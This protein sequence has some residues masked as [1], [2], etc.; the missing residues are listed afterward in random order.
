MSNWS[1]FAF[2]EEEEEEEQQQSSNPLYDQAAS[3]QVKIQLTCGPPKRAQT[4]LTPLKIFFSQQKC[5]NDLT[6]DDV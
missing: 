3:P 6:H 5:L 1:I 4:N 2:K